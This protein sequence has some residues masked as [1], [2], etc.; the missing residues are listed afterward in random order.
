M[1]ELNRSRTAKKIGGDVVVPL[2]LKG[3]RIRLKVPAEPTEPIPTYGGNRRGVE[4]RDDPDE[5]EQARPPKKGG[6]NKAPSTLEPEHTPPRPP[7]GPRAEAVL[8]LGFLGV[9]FLQRGQFPRKQVSASISRAAALTR[10]P[11][12]RDSDGRF[13][14]VLPWSAPEAW[15]NTWEADRLR[16]YED[17]IP[18]SA[19]QDDDRIAEAFTSR[20]RTL[21]ER[22]EAKAEKKRAAMAALKAS[23]LVGGWLCPSCEEWNLSFRKLCY[24]C[25]GRRTAAGV[26]SRGVPDPRRHDQDRPES[27]S[28]DS[29][30]LDVRQ[31]EVQEEWDALQG[32]GSKKRDNPYGGTH[33]GRSKGKYS[34]GRGT[35]GG[36]AAW[37][38]AGVVAST[39]RGTGLVRG[40]V[41]LCLPPRPFGRAAPL[42]IAAVRRNHFG[43]VFEP[44][45]AATSYTW[46][47]ARRVH[48]C[49]GNI[50][51][52]AGVAAALA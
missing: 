2:L 22:R 26:I 20:M 32:P 52:W 49:T 29:A 24:K 9:L 4:M 40:P 36:A 11:G 35:R 41:P 18:E 42:R 48:I 45:R 39:Y 34:R 44:V 28:D 25:N 47:F 30:A 21:A 33:G 38:S 50:S 46:A 23:L 8:Q 14:N 13:D 10:A 27:D 5:Q 12:Q 51:A 1:N 16:D 15:R 31:E 37:L 7:S 6:R 17:N 43:H 3:D 19:Y